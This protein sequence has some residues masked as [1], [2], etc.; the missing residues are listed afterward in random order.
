MEPTFLA[1]DDVLRIHRRQLEL[2]GGTPGLRDMGLLESAVAMPAAGSGDEYL[3]EDIY[4]M[5]AACLFHIVL[6]HPFTDGNKRTGAVVAMAFL[7]MNGV[8]FEVT[9]D[10]LV[11]FVL[12][13]AEGKTE[14]P[15][16]AAFFREHSSA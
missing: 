3:H 12:A 15:E 9:N 8:E 16:I 5:A 1:L 7:E 14:K 6:N 2:Y 10:Q 4:E 13:V 11:E